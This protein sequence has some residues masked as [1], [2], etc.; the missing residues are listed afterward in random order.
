MRTSNRKSCK[1][2]EEKNHQEAKK[3]NASKGI[4]HE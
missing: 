1:V 4:E 2:E 3:K